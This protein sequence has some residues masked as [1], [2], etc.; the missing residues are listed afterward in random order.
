MTTEEEEGDERSDEGH[1]IQLARKM[2][3]RLN[4]G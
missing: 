4:N 1:N 2:E 3:K